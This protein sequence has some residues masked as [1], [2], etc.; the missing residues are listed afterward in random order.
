MSSVVLRVRDNYGVKATLDILQEA[1]LQVDISAIESGEIGKLFGLSSQEFMLPGTDN[2]N[3][4]FSNMFDMGATPSIALNHTIYASVFLEHGQEIFSGR[5]YINDLITDDEGYVMYK[6]VVVDEFVDFK[7][8]IEGLTLGDLDLSFLNHDFNYGNVTSSWDAR[9]GTTDGLVN[10]NVVYPLVDYGSSLNTTIAV[11]EGQDFS[12]G[13]VLSGSYNQYNTPLELMDFKPGVKVKSIIDAIFDKVNYNYTSSFIE[14]DYFDKI[15]MLTTNT[16]QRGIPGAN[17]T[18][19]SFRANFQGSSQIINDTDEDLLIF[20]NEVFDNGGA[21]NPATG[22]YRAEADGDFSLASGINVEWNTSP[23]AGEYRQLILR[24][25]KNGVTIKTSPVITSANTNNAYVFDVTNNVV[26]GDLFTITAEN[27]TTV[28][29]FGP[30]GTGATMRV[31]PNNSYFRGEKQG[32]IVTGSVDMATMFSPEIAVEDFLTAIIERFNLVIEPQY[33]ERSILS[34]EPFNTWRDNGEVKD[35]SSIVDHSVRKSIKGTMINEARFLSFKDGEDS[36]YLNTFT[37][38]NYK[39]IFGEK[40]FEATSDLTQGTRE[41]SNEFFSPTPVI[42][43]DGDNGKFSIP[44]LYEVDNNQTK[45]G[46]A[47][48]PRLLHFIGKKDISHLAYDQNGNTAGPGFWL[49]DPFDESVNRIESPGLFHYLD[50]TENAGQLIPSD[51][52]RANVR[53]LNWN[54]S[55]QYHF[56][57]PTLGSNAYFVE[58][59][60]IYE[61]WSEYINHLYDVDTKTLTLNIKF[62]PTDLADIQLNNKIF[63]DGHYYRINN[64]SS[65]NLTRPNSTQVELIT[66]PIRFTKY[67]RR[68]IYNI[69]GP[70][71]G[72]TGSGANDTPGGGFTDLVLD[73]SSIDDSGNGTYVYWDDFLP[74]TGSGNQNIVRRASGLDGFDYYTNDSAS[75]NI[76][77]TTQQNYTGLRRNIN[78]GNNDIDW[79]AQNN[80]LVGNGNTINNNVQHSTIVGS[81]NVVEGLVNSV[82]VYGINNA[83]AES[84]SDTFIVT[85]NKTITSVS[86]SVILQPSLDISEYESGRVVVGNLRRQGNQYENYRILEGGPGETYDLANGE[87]GYFHYHL[88]YTSSVNGDTTIYLPSASLDENA[89]IQFRFT[90]DGSLDASKRMIVQAVTGEFIDGGDSESLTTTYD[91]LTIQNIENEWIVI[92]RK[93]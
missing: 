21:Y 34:I 64:I 72:M 69:E 87:S 55:D 82:Q 91:G 43:I 67:P 36:D 45:K 35:W 51:G 50:L 4:F 32:T 37:Q 30:L 22:V 25:K 71:T 68:R 86:Q 11:G 33:D 49:I 75:V 88:S 47:F 46:I 15:F 42:N 26:Q 81:G 28:G 20:P 57:S 12:T 85:S 7:Q 79:S 60:A 76:Q 40:L 52:V 5:M 70:D 53:D 56:V 29:A 66:A 48:N 27:K 58:R 2:N 19:L 89:D 78:L 44:A 63:I 39:K 73:P 38:D 16:D 84:V 62:E 83:I 93:K 10:G 80:I 24:L 65:F 14:G 74:P 9:A 41:I 90:T 1:E 92:Q 18:D 8:R 59:D 31:Q 3:K 13:T 23:A 17:P 61:Y 6:A 77:T 54:N